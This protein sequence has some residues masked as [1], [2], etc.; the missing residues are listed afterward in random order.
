MANFT[1]HLLFAMTVLEIADANG[2]E[3]D[4]LL[5]DNEVLQTFMDVGYTKPLILRCKQQMLS[6]LAVHFCLLGVKA[7]LDQFRKE[8]ETPHVLSAMIKQSHAFQCLFVS[9]RNPL[10]AGT[11]LHCICT[12]FS[13]QFPKQI[14]YYKYYSTMDTPPTLFIQLYILHINL[15]LFQLLLQIPSVHL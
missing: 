7:E 11:V 4:N 9:E 13:F 12:R 2:L 6:A 10:T 15:H 5:T 3:F 14:I 1:F 8:L